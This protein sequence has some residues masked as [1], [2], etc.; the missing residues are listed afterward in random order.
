[1]IALKPLASRAAERCSVNTDKDRRACAKCVA[2]RILRRA[3]GGLDASGFTATKIHMHNPPTS[4][5]GLTAAKAFRE[6][7]A[8]WK[9][10]DYAA[11]NLYDYQSSFHDPDGF[12]ASLGTCATPPATSP[13]W[14]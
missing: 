8:V 9:T 12:D 4:K 7:P 6:D 13:S 10:I 3:R 1:M 5:G 11:L 2:W 14:R